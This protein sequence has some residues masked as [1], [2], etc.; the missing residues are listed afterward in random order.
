V[1]FANAKVVGVAETLR[2]SLASGPMRSTNR[3]GSRDDTWGKATT[4][5][6]RER[7][8]RDAKLPLAI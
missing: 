3:D 8:L 7:L 4:F 5:A 6:D 2:G 1:L